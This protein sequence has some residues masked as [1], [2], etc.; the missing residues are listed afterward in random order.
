L[1]PYRCLFA[2]VISA[3]TTASFAAN[4]EMAVITLT[5][6]DSF[7]MNSTVTNCLLTH[8]LDDDHELISFSLTEQA[9]SATTSG[10][11]I[12]ITFGADDNGRLDD[13]Q[14]GHG[15]LN[16][17][18]LTPAEKIIMEAETNISQLSDDE[19]F[20]EQKKAKAV[21]RQ[22]TP[23]FSAF[24][25]TANNEGFGVYADAIRAKEKFPEL[26]TANVEITLNNI[27]VYEVSKNAPIETA[28]FGYAGLCTVA[29]IVG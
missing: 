11:S 23:E 3:W 22:S 6:S 8:K 9:S 1:R 10:K 27:A 19:Y 2:V 28:S 7:S 18:S 4:P 13:L 16:F 17:Q 24:T 21:E 12:R 25:A 29:I 15:S 14:I 26:R 5:A 20:A